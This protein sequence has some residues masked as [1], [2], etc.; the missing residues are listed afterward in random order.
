MNEQTAEELFRA[1]LGWTRRSLDER[2]KRLL[3]ALQELSAAMQERNALRGELQALRER[4][5]ALEA[6]R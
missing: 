5:A 2:E 6:K 3:P 1:I 4:V